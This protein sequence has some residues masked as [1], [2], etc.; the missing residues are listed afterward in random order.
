[1]RPAPLR[2]PPRLFMGAVGGEFSE[3]A[4][5]LFG[6][7]LGRNDSDVTDHARDSGAVSEVAQLDFAAGDLRGDL[8]AFCFGAAFDGV[9]VRVHIGV[10]FEFL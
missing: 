4:I 6:G 7:E 5:T 3:A 10:W 9:F 2:D 8:I 1:L